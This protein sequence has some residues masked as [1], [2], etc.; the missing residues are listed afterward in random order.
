MLTR[1][2]NDLAII[3]KLGDNPGSDNGMTEEQL[4]AKFDEA[5]LI[6]QAYINETLLPELEKTVEWESIVNTQDK[7]IAAAQT[8]AS[9]ALEAAKGAVKRSGD[10]MTGNL[11]VPTPTEGSHA[12]T[13]EYVDSRTVRLTATLPA[14][15]WSA[16]APYSQQVIVAGVIPEKPPH[17]SP[18]YSAGN[19]AALMEACACVTYA[20]AGTDLI[21]FVCLSDKPQVDIPIQ[22]EVHR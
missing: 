13:K 18:V 9:E 5:A 1:L 22:V 3:A 16:G 6:I 21:T 14:A 12:A 2:I 20:T 10:T 11:N 8:A 19:A 15:G 4:K 7:K 17:V